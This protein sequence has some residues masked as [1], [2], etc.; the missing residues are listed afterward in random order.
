MST[1]TP[2]SSSY[3]RK[4]KHQKVVNT[5]YGRGLIIRTRPE[6]NVQE[7]EL[8]DWP[9]TL[10]KKPPILYAATDSFKSVTPMVGDDVVCLYGRGRVIEINK[11]ENTCVVELSSWRLAQ[12]SS[13]KC[14]LSIDNNVWVVRKKTLYEMD[15]FEKVTYAQEMKQ[16]ATDH[17]QKK[18][19]KEALQEY[20]K[21]VAAVRFVQH[22]SSSTNEL[23][24]DLLLLMITCCNNA[25]TCCILLREWNDA[26]KFATN[27][28][29]LLEALYE[30]R[31]M[32]VHTILNKE[33]IS[34]MKLFGEFKTKS[35]LLQARGYLEL[36]EY[37]KCLDALKQAHAVI[38]TFVESGDL[39]DPAYQQSYQN[40]HKQSVVLKRMRAS[41]Q[42]RRK[43]E[44]QKEKQRAQAMFGSPPLSATKKKSVKISE[45]T[46]S[47]SSEGKIETKEPLKDEVP[48]PTKVKRRVSFSEDT[49]PGKGGAAEELLEYDDM[50]EQP[51]Y[52]EHKEALILSG[53][54]GLAALTTT[55]LLRSR[56][57]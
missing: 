55:I 10:N 44:L 36:G 11:E 17:F 46:S 50:E 6:D 4:D 28:L 34:D 43:G 23:R 27:A 8:L 20:D 35:L 53:I 13:V 16:A 32:R 7:V 15:A 41:C 21:A 39:Q 5:P 25:G 9:F 33:G 57:K 42:E 54:V 22:D 45:S 3:R 38:S 31:G 30:K 29:V 19:T 18:Q 14:Y 51:W 48:R 49:K 12:R 47:I 2:V 26:I 24:A 37:N 1:K 56:K 52:E 40:L